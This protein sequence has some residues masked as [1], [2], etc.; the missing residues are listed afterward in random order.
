MQASFT[1][2]LCFLFSMEE[3][4]ALCTRIAIMVNGQFK[5]MGSPQHLKNKFGE[6]YTLI[7]KV[8]YPTE[9]A[10]QPNTQ[11]FIT[12]IN[13][14]FPGSILKD[15]HQVK[16]VIKLKLNG[17]FT[18]VFPNYFAPCISFYSSSYKLLQRSLNP[19]STSRNTCFSLNIS[20]AFSMVLDPFFTPGN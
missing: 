20:Q 3:C 7:A 18:L 15:V 9:G 17:F 6:G 5:C 2:Y 10:S 1:Y 16:V 4:E 8:R 19:T 14:T 12:F 11:A 13:S